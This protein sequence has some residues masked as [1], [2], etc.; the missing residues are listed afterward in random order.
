MA[1]PQ[2]LY[3]TFREMTKSDLVTTQKA[4]PE[5]MLAFQNLLNQASPVTDTETAQRDL[6]RRMYFSSPS[7]FMSYVGNRHNQVS[8]LVLW[9][10][11]KCI[12]RYFNLT[13]VVHIKWTDETKMYT[14]NPYV[15]KDQR[16]VPETTDEPVAKK[17]PTSKPKPSGQ[18]LGKKLPP[19][20]S[21]LYRDAVRSGTLPKSYKYVKKEQPKKKWGDEPLDEEVTKKT[22]KKKP[23]KPADDD[24]ATADAATAAANKE[25]AVDVEKDEVEVEKDE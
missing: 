10:E 4:N 11:S 1:L 12:A 13:G 9:T 25:V 22:Y 20:G 17:E 21:K 16:E 24:K 7:G 14:I 8:A 18:F 3:D 2:K 5:N 15:P 19:K 6:I 23:S